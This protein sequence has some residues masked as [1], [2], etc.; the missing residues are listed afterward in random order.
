MQG[1]I[2]RSPFPT[3]NCPTTCYSLTTFTIFLRICPP[4]S[5]RASSP[6]SVGSP[7]F[8]H[9]WGRRGIDVHNSVQSQC[10]LPWQILIPFEREHWNSQFEVHLL[11]FPGPNLEISI[12]HVLGRFPR[13]KWFRDLWYDLT[14]FLES[15]EFFLSNATL[16]WTKKCQFVVKILSQSCSFW[17]PQKNAKNRHL[18]FSNHKNNTFPLSRKISAMIWWA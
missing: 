2:S 11:K 7:N 3:C 12:K 18:E 8:V 4:W 13:T 6:A 15:L 16:V 14:P 17:C 10:R 5:C 1:C 9:I